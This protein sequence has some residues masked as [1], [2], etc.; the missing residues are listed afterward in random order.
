MAK[1]RIK[2]LTRGPIRVKGFINGPVLTPYF[3][4]ISVIF[5][6]ISQGIHVVEV[7][8]DKAEIK[9]TTNN[10]AEDNSKA[11]RE[12]RQRMLQPME[13][14]KEPKVESEVVESNDDQVTE[15]EYVAADDVGVVEDVKS[16]PE[17]NNQKHNNHTKH[18]K[19]NRK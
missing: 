16:V 19:H 7:C 15:I 8:D 9:L 11:A 4:D 13:K 12:E 17:N 2:I 5:A 18:N 10:V 3:E 14:P 6:M 1:K